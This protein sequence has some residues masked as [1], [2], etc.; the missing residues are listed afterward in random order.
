MV[1]GGMCSC[2]TTTLCIINGNMDSNKYQQV[3]QANLLP[4]LEPNDLFVQDNAPV[5][6]SRST[7]EWIE[8]H[9]IETLRWPSRSPDLNPMENVW[10]TMVRRVYAEGKQY[11]TLQELKMAILRCWQSLGTEELNNLSNSMTGRIFDCISRKGM[12]VQ[13]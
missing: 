5:H 2:K 3:L 11:S 13:Y 7:L 1:W 8:E 10:G 6:V 4:F 12:H 9:D